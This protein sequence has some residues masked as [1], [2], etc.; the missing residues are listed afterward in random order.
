MVHR[1][2]RDA[3]QQPL[4]CALANGHAHAVQAALAARTGK[5]VSQLDR[6]RHAPARTQLPRPGIRPYPSTR[7]PCADVPDER[8]A[9][10]R[11]GAD[12]VAG[13][14]PDA[15]GDQFRNRQPRG[16]WTAWRQ[17]VSLLAL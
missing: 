2:W 8:R 1:R 3:A 13:R 12:A 16:R 7:G 10:A 4:I 17:T 11:P 9:N 15:V 5:L 14:V 6:Y